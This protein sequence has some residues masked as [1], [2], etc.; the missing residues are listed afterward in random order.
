MTSR[1][2]TLLSTSIMIEESDTFVL[3]SRCSI[4]NCSIWT[5]QDGLAAK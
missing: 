1:A 4:E 3:V 2:H 5:L